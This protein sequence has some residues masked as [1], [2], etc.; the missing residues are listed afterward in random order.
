MILPMT[1]RHEGHADM[2]TP[3][4][5]Q[6]DTARKFTAAMELPTAS[7]PVY[8]TILDTDL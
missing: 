3:T 2:T 1:H 4:T 6:P 8:T 5:T 7:A